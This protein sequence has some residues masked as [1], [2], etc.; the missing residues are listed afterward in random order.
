MVVLTSAHVQ[1]RDRES[2]K[3]RRIINKDV[4]VVVCWTSVGLIASSLL[5]Y[6]DMFLRWNQ[7]QVC[8]RVCYVLKRAPLHVFGENR[9]TQ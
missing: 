6:L 5:R 7:T 3:S 4:L 9:E 2:N 1:E 8:A